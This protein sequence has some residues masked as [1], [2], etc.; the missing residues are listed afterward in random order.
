MRLEVC[1]NHEAMSRAAAALLR[2]E[3][4]ARPEAL[5]GIATGSTPTRAYE[6]LAAA[7][8][9]APALARQ[10]RLIAI[11][12]WGGL[13]GPDPATCD[14]YVRKHVLE[15]MAIDESRYTHFAT[16]TS[17]RS[18]ECERVREWLAEHGPIDLCVLGL[19]TNGHVALV[20]PAAELQR[21][22][23][24]ATLSAAALSHS[25]LD[26]AAHRPAFGLTLG[27]DEILGS[28]RIVLLVSGAHKKTQLAR[29]LDGPISTRFPASLLWLH[30]HT[31]LL[32][33]S[34]A[35]ARRD[36]SRTGSRA[37]DDE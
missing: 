16:D 37:R 8:H 31:T 28:R 17:D 7:T 5:L 15:P 26:C 10:A 21:G 36:E 24:V 27:I 4:E 29:L 14:A 22:A 12:E 6:L 30:P 18:H 13:P 33:T 1:D 34:D 19:G 23:H 9:G 11:D 3:L 25:M 20:E 35:M 2:S 32:L